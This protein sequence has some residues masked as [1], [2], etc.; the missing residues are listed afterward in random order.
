[1][2][3]HDSSRRLWVL[4]IRQRVAVGDHAHVR[5]VASF[6]VAAHVGLDRVIG[7]VGRPIVGVGGPAAGWRWL[8]VLASTFVPSSVRPRTCRPH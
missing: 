2:A 7:Q 1:M 4:P 8:A 6:L 3:S 5:Q